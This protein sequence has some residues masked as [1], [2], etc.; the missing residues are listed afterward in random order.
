MME[1]NEF[2]HEIGRRW[3]ISASMGILFSRNNTAAMNGVTH[4]GHRL[5]EISLE[6]LPALGIHCS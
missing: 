4:A 1:N 3:R 2:P 5:E 6:E